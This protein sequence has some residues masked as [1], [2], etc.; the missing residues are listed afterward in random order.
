LGLGEFLGKRGLSGRLVEYFAAN[1]GIIGLLL[2]RGL[3]K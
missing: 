2:K 1:Y 3:W